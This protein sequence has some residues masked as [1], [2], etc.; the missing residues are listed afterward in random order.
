M[1]MPCAHAG[2]QLT[3]LA[4]AM[5]ALPAQPAS[6][7]PPLRE[8]AARQLETQAQRTPGLDALNAAAALCAAS[9]GRTGSAISPSMVPVPALPLRPVQ[10]GPLLSAG[11]VATQLTLPGA[12]LGMYAGPKSPAKQTVAPHPSIQKVL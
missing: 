10:D 9:D 3:Q 12:A 1:G 11:Y 7:V 8:S 5:S 4:V 6:T 2:S